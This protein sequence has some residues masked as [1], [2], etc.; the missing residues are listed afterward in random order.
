MRFG[1]IRDERGVT[2]VE[3][4]M[5]APVMIL[6]ITGSIEAG[7]YMMV[8]TALEGAVATASRESI[9]NLVLDEDTRD[10]RM[11]AR[12]KHLMSPY[13]TAPGHQIS[14]E[15]K[16][17]REI[18]DSYPEAYE[19]LND[20]GVYDEGEPF[21][22]RNRNGVRDMNVPVEGRLGDV[23][24]VIR[25]RVVYPTAPYFSLLTPIFGERIDLTTNIVSR[26]EPEKGVPAT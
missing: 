16:V 7:H 9:A 6:L 21:D 25:Y 3:F 19:D 1:L 18:G 20:N 14:I 12:I 5:L 17:Y 13:Q 10:G 22:D 2:A 23:G 4:A 15:T 11:R 24:D 8:K 26:N